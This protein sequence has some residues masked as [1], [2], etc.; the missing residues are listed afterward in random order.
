MEH[1]QEMAH[2]Q[3]NG[4]MTDDM[5]DDLTPK[6]KVATQRCLRLNISQTAQDSGLVSMLHLLEIT[7]VA[8]LRENR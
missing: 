4:H 7:W 8:S 1:L 2:G 6:V 5:T 3:P